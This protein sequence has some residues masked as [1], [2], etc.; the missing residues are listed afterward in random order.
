MEHYDIFFEEEY[1][2]FGYIKKLDS[3]FCQVKISQKVFMC[4]VFAYI[5]M[6]NICLMDTN[7]LEV[8]K[9]QSK[10]FLYPEFYLLIVC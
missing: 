1:E 4:F 3:S 10:K 8:K 7:R 9:F 5:M 2:I 6:I